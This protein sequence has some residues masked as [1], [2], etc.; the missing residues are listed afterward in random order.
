MGVPY[1]LTKIYPSPAA[2]P[3][4]VVLDAALRG[5]IRRFRLFAIA[6][7]GSIATPGMTY[8]LYNSKQAFVLDAAGKPTATLAPQSELYRIAPDVT[9]AGGTAV[10]PSGFALNWIYANT[11]GSVAT[12]NRNIY[13]RV[14]GP[15]VG[16]SLG[17]SLGIDTPSVIS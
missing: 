15:S 2:Y 9:L 11:D 7:D 17:V 12:R 8:G 4:V 1:E 13:L 6:G 10:D 14:S 5:V 3:A 16:Q